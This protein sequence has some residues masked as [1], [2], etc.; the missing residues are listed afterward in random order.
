MNGYEL[1]RKYVARANDELWSLPANPEVQN[2]LTDSAMLYALRQESKIYLHGGCLSF[3]APEPEPAPAPETDIRACRVGAQ[4]AEKVRK[5]IMAG[6]H[7]T[8][9]Y[10][11]DCPEE[12]DRREIAQI[13]CFLVGV[14]LIAF[15]IWGIR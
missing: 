8:V 12:L 14:L 1:L 11:C 7:R 5:S 15:M 13:A 2:M 4:I 6:E 9:E 10:W 3:D